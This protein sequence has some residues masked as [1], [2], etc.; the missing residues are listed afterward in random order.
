MVTHGLALGFLLIFGL[1]QTSAV[2]PAWAQTAGWNIL[3]IPNKKEYLASPGDSIR[4]TIKVRNDG[5]LT[6]TNLGAAAVDFGPNPDETGD[7]RIIE[8]DDDPYGYRLSPWL[9]FDETVQALGA[10]ES[11]EFAYTINIPADA[12]PGGHYGM[13]YIQQKNTG[14]GQNA[15]GILS[16]LGSLILV[17]VRGDVRTEG[18]LIEFYPGQKLYEYLPVDLYTRI[19]N[20]GNV[21]IRPVGNIFVYDWRDKM[22][23]TLSVNESAGGVLPESVRRFQSYWTEALLRN[24]FERDADG[25]VLKAENG[26][27]KKKLEIRWEDWNLFRFGRY[28]A[29]TLI[30]YEDDNLIEHHLEAATYF[31]VIPW[32]LMLAILLGILLLTVLIRW[33]IRRYNDSIIARYEKGRGK[34]SLELVETLRKQRKN[35]RSKRAQRRE[36]LGAKL[37]SIQDRAERILRWQ[38]ESTDAASTAE[39]GSSSDR[40][41]QSKDKHDVFHDPDRLD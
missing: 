14:E 4:G 23:G 35:R 34:V 7:P 6:L 18:N 30:V 38:P 36:R 27:Q 13:I 2:L 16:K 10:G 3:L 5:D 17:T 15:V 29:R 41:S 28:G 1:L 37:L 20:V 9:S 39:A 12:E 25:N 19:E 8:S 11:I 32:K 21:H 40:G 26:E 22:V 31:W 24:D 33:L